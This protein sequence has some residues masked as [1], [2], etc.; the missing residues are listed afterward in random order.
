MKTANEI[1]GF[2]NEC[3]ENQE[4]DSRWKNLD[5]TKFSCDVGYVYEWWEQFKETLIKFA[6]EK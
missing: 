1:I 5:G 3:M 6:E 2:I 4:Y